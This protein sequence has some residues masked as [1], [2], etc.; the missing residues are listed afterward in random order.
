MALYVSRVCAYDL[1][2]FCL[3]VGCILRENKLSILQALGD[4]KHPTRQLITP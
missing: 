4:S 3:S 2:L 1:S